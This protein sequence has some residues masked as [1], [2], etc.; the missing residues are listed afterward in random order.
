MGQQTTASCKCGYSFRCSIGG[1]KKATP[2]QTKFPHYCA[3]CGVVNASPYAERRDCP[4]CHSEP[5][6]RYGIETACRPFYI[7]GFR[8]RF[9]DRT[10]RSWDKTVSIPVGEVRFMWGEFSVTEGDHLCPGCGEMNLRFD[11]ESVCFID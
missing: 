9:L 10:I 4:Q 2:E 5:L 7:F 11:D 6:V 1:S 8:L 3:T